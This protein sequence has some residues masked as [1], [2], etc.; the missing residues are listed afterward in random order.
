MQLVECSSQRRV[1]RDTGGR[2]VGRARTK[3]FGSAGDSAAPSRCGRGE[4]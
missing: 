1:L 2:I 3:G 4:W